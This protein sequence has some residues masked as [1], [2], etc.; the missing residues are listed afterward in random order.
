MLDCNQYSAGKFAR[1]KVT[2]APHTNAGSIRGLYIRASG[3]GEDPERPASVAPQS[4]KYKGVAIRDLQF[5]VAAIRG[6]DRHCR[7]LRALPEAQ[8]PSLTKNANKRL[9]A[10][11]KLR[12]ELRAILQARAGAVSGRLAGTLDAQ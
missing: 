3:P 8:R 2:L 5:L 4:K 12:I 10:D 11:P 6:S 7:K 9:S 1:S